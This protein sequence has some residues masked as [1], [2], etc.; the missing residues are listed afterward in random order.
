MAKG[1]KVITK[2]DWIAS[3]NLVG[4]AKLNEYTY[5][6]NEKSEKSSWIYNSLNLGVYC[7][8]KY[9]TVYVSMMGGYSEEK[10]GVIFAH[11]KK[12]D[13]SDDFENQIQVAWEDRF[14]EDILESLGDM[15][16]ITVGLEQT[17]KNKVFYKKFLSEYDA[18]AY[19][20]EHLEE[21]MVLNVRGNI[22]YSLYQEKVQMQKNINNIVLSKVDDAAKYKATF[23]QTVL[24]NKDSASLKKEQI[25]KD[26]GV[27]YVSTRILDYLKEFNG[28]E[29]KGQYP[30]QKEFEFEMDF[31]NEKICKMIMEKVFKVKKDV[32]QITFEGEF[33]SG[34]AVVTA[35]WDD[36]P[37]DIKDLVEC[38]IYTKE[39]ALQRCSTNGNREDRMILHKPHTRLV[40]DEKKPMVQKFEQRFT[41]N[42]LTLDYLV[43]EAPADGFMNVPEGEELP[44][45]DDKK[46]DT[47]SGEEG[48]VDDMSWLN[49]L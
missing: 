21:G 44:F 26:K 13:G 22:R 31:S 42:D 7:G 10:A 6:I 5:K 2:K 25:D 12:E 29:V 37:D 14:D 49:N 19:I 33:I 46:D 32:T 39:E 18:I 4:E 45:A 17:N 41:E 11:G 38:G 8:E 1:K 47:D 34:G 15:C 30:F 43:Q 48:S 23:V 40:G 16:F 35:T 27:L 24:L 3:F 36:V 20:Q 9:G 28:I